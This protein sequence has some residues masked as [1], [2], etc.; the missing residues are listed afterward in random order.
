MQ[1]QIEKKAKIKRIKKKED[2][3]SKVINLLNKN[4]FD[5]KT[6]ENLIKYSDVEVSFK[7]YLFFLI[8]W[9]K[10]II[11]QTDYKD[12]YNTIQDYKPIKNNPLNYDK[13]KKYSHSDHVIVCQ[14]LDKHK[15]D[16][17]EKFNEETGDYLKYYNCE[18]ESWIIRHIIEY[19]SYQ[20]AISEK[21]NTDEI[22][23]FAE[24]MIKNV[25]NITTFD[26][27]CQK[28]VKSI[29]E[30]KKGRFL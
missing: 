20:Y 25:K 21:M 23:P 24:Y 10:K 6:L 22:E 16:S 30:K 14:S 9:N 13:I 5:V 17:I 15:H 7:N 12:L 19:F 28:Y 8:I 4:G 1:A 27:Y 29:E 18:E 26:N 11:K 3:C 2:Y